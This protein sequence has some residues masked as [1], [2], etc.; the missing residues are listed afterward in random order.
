MASSTITKT[1]CFKAGDTINV[2]NMNFSAFISSGSTEIVFTIPCYKSL[3][4]ITNFAFNAG[5]KIAVRKAEGDYLMSD[6]LLNTLSVVKRGIS[7]NYISFYIRKTD[8]TA[9][10]ATNN[11]ILDVAFVG[12]NN[13][14]T[15]S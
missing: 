13:I 12:T 11:S 9:F 8:G 4:N 15:F 5:A 7:D 2:S 1:D 10:S 3:S 14:I 6:T